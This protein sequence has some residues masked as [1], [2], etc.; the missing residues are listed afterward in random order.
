MASIR[1]P[2][3]LP[4]FQRFF[5]D[6]EHCSE[7][8]EDM[9]WPNGF[10]CPYCGHAGEPYRIATRLGVLECRSCRRQVSLTADT[11][12]HRS[13][14]PL[15]T[16][17]WG[18]YLVSSLT[19]GLSAVQFQRQLGLSRYET[20]FQMLHKLR[21][22]MVR[23]DR[24]RIGGEWP[25]EVDETLIGGRTRGEG[26]GTH[27]K[28]VVAGAVEVRQG[29]SGEKLAHDQRRPRKGKSYAGR[30]RIHV[31]ANRGKRALEGF[32]EQSVEPGS[33]VL[34]DACNGYND[35]DQ[36]GYD[37]HK[38]VIGGDQEKT[39]AWLPMIHLIFSNLK[40]WLQGTH[41]GV[42]QQHLQAYLNEFTFRFN[43]R[44]YPFHA[45]NSLLGIGVE[46]ESPT[47][48]ELY[49]GEWQHPNPEA[50]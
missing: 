42:S 32:V 33:Q 15:C 28:V 35:L 27:H 20:A 47:Y 34:T 39:E 45:F 21:A 7:Y 36:L 24:D 22:G 3:S 6:E 38:V 44:F 41:H 13:R 31:V 2:E 11:V 4:E 25:V 40:A 43:R 37:H 16:W 5:P 14:T 18:A 19:P 23:P 50:G 26:R 12:M 49:S 17:F 46:V 48:E 9:R 1:F 30:L 8:L 29:K 10:V